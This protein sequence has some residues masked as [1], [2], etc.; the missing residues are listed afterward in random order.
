MQEDNS[1]DESGDNSSQQ[2]QQ[3]LN[4]KSSNSRSRQRGRPQQQQQQQ[5]KQQSPPAAKQAKPCHAPGK[6]RT[7]AAGRAAAAEA[8]VTGMACHRRGVLTIGNLEVAPG[9][10]V[11]LALDNYT[12]EEEEDEACEVRQTVPVDWTLRQLLRLWGAL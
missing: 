6:G 7:R 11:Y 8:A 2:Q 12:H 3:P 4:G 1:E 10:D 9:D 5:Q